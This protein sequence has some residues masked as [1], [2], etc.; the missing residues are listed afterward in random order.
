MFWQVLCNAESEKTE[1][2]DPTQFHIV[3]VTK[4]GRQ[5]QSH[6]FI[7]PTSQPPRIKCRMPT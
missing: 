7:S 5:V 4:F 1:G 3:T 6:Y 2:I